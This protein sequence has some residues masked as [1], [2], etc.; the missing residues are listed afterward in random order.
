M[1]VK[2]RLLVMLNI[3][4]HVRIFFSDKSRGFFSA[5]NGTVLPAGASEIYLEMFEISP[6]IIINVD[7]ND[8]FYQ[9]QKF[10]HFGF[11]FQKF[12]NAN[13]AA[14]LCFILLNSSRIKD[15]AAVASESS[16]V[17]G[18]IFWD[19]AFF[20]GET[21]YIDCKTNIFFKL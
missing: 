4:F 6:K 3:H 9:V 13:I 19:S 8:A 7:G 17:S 5:V 11:D 18:S 2:L 15:S 21:V 14:G 16:A 20:V 12:L 10:R 1:M